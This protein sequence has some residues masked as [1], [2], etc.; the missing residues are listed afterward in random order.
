MEK[1]QTPPSA[2]CPACG[3][4]LRFKAR[5]CGRCGQAV[6]HAAQTA[7][8]AQTAGPPETPE[9][10]ETLETPAAT[11]A[12]GPPPPPAVFKMFGHRPDR[13]LRELFFDTGVALTE[14][15]RFEEA[16]AAFQQAQGEDGDTPTDA[17]VRIYLAAALQRTGAS[18]KA[19]RAY[20]TFL[21]EAPEH[22][23]LV[24]PTAHGLLT[25]ETASEAG[26]WMAAAWF[27]NARALPLSELAHMRILLFAGRVALFLANYD[28]ALAL[29]TE[30]V[31]L[32]PQ[33][34][35]EEGLALITS[36]ALPPALAGESPDGDACFLLARLY[37]LFGEQTEA[38]AWT[39]KALDRGL[40]GDQRYPLAP[41]E[42]LKGELLLA[43][44]RGAD[45]A[46]WLYRAGAGYTWRGEYETAAE[47]LSMAHAQ[48]PADPLICWQWTDAL[49]MLSAEA[50]EKDR[51][52]DYLKQSLR[53]WERITRR[54]LP[55]A[56]NSWP[57][58]TRALLNELR[59][60]LETAAD[61]PLWWEALAYLERA[62]LLND[63]DA[64]T[65]AYLGR[66]NR[67]LLLEANS[68]QATAKAFELAPDNLLVL[69][70]RMSIL[71]DTGRFSE[72]E[73]CMQAYEALSPDSEW[74]KGVRAFIL[75]QT[76]QYAAAKK[77][78][79]E[80]ISL[81]PD[82]L[83]YRELRMIA[84]LMLQAPR[85]AEHDGSAILA[86]TRSRDAA[87]RN[88]AALAQYY[89]ALIRGDA[90][91]L[92]K[93]AQRFEALG[94][95]PVDA[96]VANR[97]LGFCSLARGDLGRGERLLRASI[98][99]A[100]NLR[101]LNEIRDLDFAILR[102]FASEPPR[103]EKINRLL[104]DLE[105]LI[106]DRAQALAEP[107][108]P[109]AE[110]ADALAAL[111]NR[112]EPGS[113][114]WIAAHAGQARL[115]GEEAN[116]RDAGTAYRQ[117][118]EH[119]ERF[120]EA[121]HGLEKALM[122]DTTLYW[123]LRDSLSDAEASGSGD[124]GA[125]DPASV[126]RRSLAGYLG[127]AF[128]L[129][130][131]A[132]QSHNMLPAVTPVAVEISEALLPQG[133]SENWPLLKTHIPEMRER[134][135][136]ETGVRVPGVR[137]RGNAGD[138]PPDAYIIML[139]EV[140]LVMG[141][142]RP[143]M[144]FCPSPA[145]DLRAAGIDGRG[146]I[147]ADN[148]L[149]GDPGCWIARRWWAQCERNGLSLWAEPLVFVVH[150]LEALLRENLDNFLGV[151]AVS[152]LL[153]EWEGETDGAGLIQTVLPDEAARFGFARLLREL[154]KERVPITAWREILETV[155]RTGTAPARQAETL[156]A[157]RLRLKSQL[158]GNRENDRRI[159]VPAEIEDLLSPW[160]WEQKE[161][162]F[163]AI[164][165]EETQALLAA[166]RELAD[167][168]DRHAVL[169]IARPPLR[170]F[171]RRLVEIEFPHMM[172]ATREELMPQ[173]HLAV[174]AVAGQ[175]EG[176][177]VNV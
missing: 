96:R 28:R 99:E 137:I 109:L 107:R 171:L 163:L 67:L 49:R 143:E 44:G 98:G 113:W 168:D 10:P 83:W 47:L 172:V 138:L 127:R 41:L 116:W 30:A 136:A 6:D 106:P 159:T 85:L 57:Y 90:G 27:E 177:E 39:D 59:A 141:S 160:I 71:A 147:E 155:G 103:A 101:E 19:L 56:A 40:S 18:G 134:I 112:G 144:R 131:D 31:A 161:A 13:S 175:Q 48:D 9:T 92:D 133:T 23:E 149:T 72:A 117:L 119:P 79:D 21:L 140:P 68:L 84:H 102:K 167:A 53:V 32:A 87:N 118:L 4:R 5:F 97:N 80:L 65:W 3:A 82:G 126:I 88:M 132:G 76:G 122:G 173:A 20:L 86:D 62:L 142:V 110:L 2:Y 121:R 54:Q 94:S 38:L 129:S 17:E 158:P 70:E 81:A 169:V 164:P 124:G 120:P 95:H 135:R 33:N 105:A 42:R 16:A 73:T 148:P 55:D 14:E 162:P 91:L 37:R 165:P 153:Q 25:A 145:E 176:G 150:H 104:A 29:F 50:R 156:R 100:A 170:P 78:L 114:P 128:Q 75:L 15:N 64:Y 157:L 51:K 46:R 139:D 61:W 36:A 11:P 60:D 69:E 146:L 12:P 22:C 174:E 89:L 93:A 123:A 77:V 166:V 52:R 24:L 115:L 130:A 74:L 45:A 108:P 63:G 8:T 26:E 7:Q 152:N 154:I 1:P 58:T 111:K 43:A 34:A 125:Q 35:P 66:F 151:Q